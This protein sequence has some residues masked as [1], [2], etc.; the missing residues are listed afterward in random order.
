MKLAATVDF[1]LYPTDIS[2]RAQSARGWF[3]PV[4]FL[5]KQPALGADGDTA[6]EL[7]LDIGATPL[8]PGERRRI[9]CGFTFQPSLEAF[10]RAKTFYVWD[11]RIIGEIALAEPGKSK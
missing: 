4:G 6:H 10:M 5:Q 11:G 3:R 8:S 9:N 2:G 7:I 1:Y